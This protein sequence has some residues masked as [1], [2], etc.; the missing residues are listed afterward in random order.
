MAF[1]LAFGKTSRDW[2]CGSIVLP[3]KQ[4]KQIFNKIDDVRYDIRRSGDIA[5]I[6]FLG[7]SASIGLLAVASIFRTVKGN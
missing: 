2:S 6:G 3:E 1:D 4:Q 7:L 5:K